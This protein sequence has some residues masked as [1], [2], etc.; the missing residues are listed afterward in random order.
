MS[1]IDLGST[2]AAKRQPARVGLLF[3]L[4]LAAG[5]VLSANPDGTDL[6]TLIEEG[7]KLKWSLFDGP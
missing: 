7:R 3:F 2:D 4:D 1:T 5:R 6:T